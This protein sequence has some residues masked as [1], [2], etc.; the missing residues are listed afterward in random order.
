MTLSPGSAE[1]KG[2]TPQQRH[3]T[4]AED[5]TI[6]LVTYVLYDR[7]GRPIACRLCDQADRWTV[8]GEG[9]VF[10]CEHE[11]IALSR[12]AIRQLS[13]VPA[14]RVAA[15]EFVGLKKPLHVSG[16]VPWIGALGT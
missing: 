5:A 10:V 1:N 8:E 11:P 15:F 2:N 6:A 12:G 3:D 7:D 13:S 4:S 14:S 16:M 9:V